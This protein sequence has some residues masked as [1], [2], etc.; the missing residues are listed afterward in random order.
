[1]KI[2]NRS[3]HQGTKTPRV[4]RTKERNFRI[5]K[6]GE[7]TVFLR[8]NSSPPFLVSWRL[9]GEEAFKGEEK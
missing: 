5:F 4:T 7:T 6:K 8:K 2:L 1:M 3:Y 9:G